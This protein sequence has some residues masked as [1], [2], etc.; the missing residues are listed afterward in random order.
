MPSLMRPKNR[1]VRMKRNWADAREEYNQAYEENMPDIESAEQDIAD[2]RAELE[3]IE[4][5][6]WYVLDRDYF[7][8]CVEYAQDAERIGAIGEVFPFIFFLVRH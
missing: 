5:P 3:D 2:A 7:Q 1:S 6:E 4:V 8:S